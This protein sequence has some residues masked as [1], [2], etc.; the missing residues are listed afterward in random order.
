MQG[1]KKHLKFQ[2]KHLSIN[3]YTYTEMATK[4]ISITEE[5]YE[6]L[7]TRKTGNESFSEIITKIVGTSSIMDIAGVLSD[8]EADILERHIKNRRQE[9]RKRLEKIRAKL[10]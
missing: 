2:Q 7:K 4:T 8:N 3:T 6:L 5:A 9:S 10:S 1:Y